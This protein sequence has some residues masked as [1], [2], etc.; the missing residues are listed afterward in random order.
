MGVL[1]L[2]MA[3]SEGTG[4]AGDT[5]GLSFSGHSECV[6]GGCLSNR[7][8]WGEETATLASNLDDLT[9]CC[10]VCVHSTPSCFD[11]DRGCIEK[12]IAME[13]K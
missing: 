1:A 3:G 11:T 7:P 4:G 2:S 5:F 8:A 9:W 13:A 10:F 12:L 6:L